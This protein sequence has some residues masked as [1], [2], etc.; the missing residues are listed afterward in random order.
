[1]LEEGA[2]AL[3]DLDFRT[4]ASDLSGGDFPS[5]RRLADYLGENADRRVMLVGHT[6]SQGSPA[7]NRALSEARARAV[8]RHLV[9]VLGVDPAQ[10]GADGVGDLAP[11]ATNAT[12]EGRAANRRVEVV[13]LDGG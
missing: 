3:D 4:G 11:R 1:M 7:A 12:P 9:D 10:V 13:L 5:L 6:D 2:A 8:R